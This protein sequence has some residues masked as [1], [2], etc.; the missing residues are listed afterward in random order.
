MI[1]KIP[2]IFFYFVDH[3]RVQR[4]YVYRPTGHIQVGPV[5]KNLH[6]D[7]RIHIA[8]PPN[9]I[10]NLAPVNMPYKPITIHRS[11]PN[12]FHPIRINIGKIP[13][14]PLNF[15][16]PHIRT[17]SVVYTNR[18]NKG[19]LDMNLVSPRRTGK[20]IVHPWGGT[21]SNKKYI[22][23]V[24]CSYDNK[25]IIINN[26]ATSTEKNISITTPK[27][28]T[29]SSTLLKYTT[30][31]INTIPTVDK[32]TNVTTQVIYPTVPAT[33]PKTIFTKTTKIDPIPVISITTPKTVIM[34]STIITNPIISTSKIDVLSK[35]TIKDAK[36][37]ILVTTPKLE[38]TT[39]TTTTV[40]RNTTATVPKP[41]T[42]VPFKIPKIER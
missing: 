27:K 39:A 42:A 7:Y 2:N 30:P 34:T 20:P 18:H 9:K 28:L 14:V 4:G 8:P 22:N 10:F 41:S 26:T 31:I 19:K 36:P 32:Y 16:V 21:S 24:L 29:E 33:T 37:I 13:T 25:T 15:N 11:I 3:G 38:S 23:I 40:I 35:I 1:T 12:A 17:P 6:N 5:Y